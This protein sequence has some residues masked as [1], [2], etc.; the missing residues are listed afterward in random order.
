MLGALRAT[1][2]GPAIVAAMR[3][4]VL[5]AAAALHALVGAGTPGEVPVVLEFVADPS[6]VVRDEALAAA[7]ALLDPRRPDGR[8]V[9]PLAAALRDP[10]PA[11]PQ[12][13]RM[14]MLL[15]RTGAARAAPLLVEL[16][17]AQDASLRLAAIDALAVLGPSDDPAAEDA[18]LRALAASDAVLRLHAALALA[19]AG[20]SARARGAAR[21][22]RWG[23]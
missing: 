1:G 12:R 8:A 3:R 6:P 18:L 20:R 14:A 5:P 9:E 7:A 4:G 17:R 13:A 22:A 23:R 16:A 10:R 2:E 11:P 19:Q 21:P 15:G